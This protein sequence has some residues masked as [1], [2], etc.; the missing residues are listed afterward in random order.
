MELPQPRQIGAAVSPLDR[1]KTAPGLV[2]LAGTPLRDAQVKLRF[3]GAAQAAQG[4]PVSHQRQR[5][6]MCTGGRQGQAQAEGS[7][8]VLGRERGGLPFGQTGAVL[9][10]RAMNHRSASP[11]SIAMPL[12]PWTWIA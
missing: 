8:A 9:C 2:E 10:S 6:L 12:P 4:Q 1:R 7:V 5:A 3:V 11:Y